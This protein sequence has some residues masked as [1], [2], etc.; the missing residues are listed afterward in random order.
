MAERLTGK[1]AVITGASTGMGKGIALSF[2]KEGANVVAVARRLERLEALKAEAE[3]LGLGDK[4]VIMAGDV[5]K[6]DDCVAAF[7]C[8]DKNFGTCN[9]L[10]QNAGIMDNFAR[11]ADIDDEV[12]EKVIAVNMTGV[13]YMLRAG[14]RFF[15]AHESPASVIVTTSDAVAQQATGGS[16]YSASKCGA[17]GLIGAAAFEY[18]NKGIRFNQ[19]CPGA[20]MT[21]ISESIGSYSR[22]D[23]E[24]MQY[25]RTHGYNAHKGEWVCK[26]MGTPEDIAPVA[27]F[28]AS[29]ESNFVNNQRIMVNG[30]LN[31]G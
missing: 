28:L 27:V 19:I 18:S 25:H 24:G 12:W 3:A 20:V 2:L 17:A 29:D 4:L 16:A 14:I 21:N 6:S 31:L 1:N 13:M 26:E 22:V 8:C 23:M 9:V 5:S 7:E 15:L 10:V 11:V 30:G